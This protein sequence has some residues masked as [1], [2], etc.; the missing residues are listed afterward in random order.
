MGDS[1]PV[2]SKENNSK[3]VQWYSETAMKRPRTQPSVCKPISLYDDNQLRTYARLL[4]LRTTD[5]N[6]VGVGSPGIGGKDRDGDGGGGVAWSATAWPSSA[7]AGA[8][9]SYLQRMEATRPLA[10]EQK[11]TWKG[12]KLQ[13]TPRDGAELGEGEADAHKTGGQKNT[14]QTT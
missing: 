12:I 1:V 2:S 8:W 5:F 7:G 9:T 10:L 13:K 14:T 4:Y 3:D 6:R 11:D